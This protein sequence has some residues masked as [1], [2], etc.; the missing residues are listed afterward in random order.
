M[1][2]EAQSVTPRPFIAHQKPLT[3]LDLIVGWSNAFLV[4]GRHPIRIPAE[5]PAIYLSFNCG[6]P[7]TIQMPGYLDYSTMTC[8]YVP[9]N[10]A[11]IPISHSTSPATLTLLFP[12]TVPVTAFI[13]SAYQSSCQSQQSSCQSHKS[14]CQSHKSSCPSQLT[15]QSLQSPFQ[16]QLLCQSHQSLRIILPVPPITML[17]PSVILSVPIT[18]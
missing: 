16:S 14:L 5:M 10:H 13:I 1:F 7:Q 11:E 18:L 9:F 15:S 2:R 6:F 8:K 12:P 3:A 17:D 4:F